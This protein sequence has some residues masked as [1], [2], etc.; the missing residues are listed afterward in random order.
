VNFHL[1]NAFRKL[2]TSGRTMAVVR[3]I[4]L[5]LISP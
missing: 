2:D 4:T 5:G 3:A 1:Q